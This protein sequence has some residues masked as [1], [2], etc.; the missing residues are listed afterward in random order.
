LAIFITLW[1]SKVQ[2]AGYKDTDQYWLAAGLFS[3]Y[4]EGKG[5]G[6]SPTDNDFA[7]YKPFI[8]IPFK[9]LFWIVFLSFSMLSLYPKT[10]V[11]HCARPKKIY[12]DKTQSDFLFQMIL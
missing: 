10:L 4:L 9:D 8:Y 7:Q 3:F 2:L 5:Q 6:H 1:N 11:W 12:G